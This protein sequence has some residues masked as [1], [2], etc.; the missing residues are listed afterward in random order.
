M[1]EKVLAI[2]VAVLMAFTAT[3]NATTQN[4]T[5]QTSAT[6]A[7][8]K[9]TYD[10]EAIFRG[11]LLGDGPVAKLFPEVW[12]SPPLDRFMRLA[13]EQGS[14]K[15]AAAAKQRIIDALRAQD[16]TFFSRFATELQSGDRVRTQQAVAEA[17]TRL[18]Q[19]IN[20]W[21]GSTADVRPPPYYYSYLYLYLYVYTAIAVFL[22]AAGAVV[23]VVVASKTP[24]DNSASNLQR[25]VYIDLIAQRLGP[26]TAK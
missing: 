8:T 19:E 23:V 5:T 7:Q 20:S 4:A 18:Q 26:T 10:G 3:G 6:T 1:T 11:I 9:T 15:D 16:P 24:N 21:M 13:E 12:E 25:D 14:Q 2:F 22:V 17:G